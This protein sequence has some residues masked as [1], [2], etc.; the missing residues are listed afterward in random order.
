MNNMSMN[1]I[2]AE[3]EYLGNGSVVPGMFVLPM[4]YYGNLTDIFNTDG[5]SSFN[6][7]FS[8]TGA[9]NL[10]LIGETINQNVAA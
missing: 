6:L 8:T 10:T 5:L 3:N 4:T 7:N 2:K 9:C 1:E